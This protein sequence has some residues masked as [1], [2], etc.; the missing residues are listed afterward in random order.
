VNNVNPMGMS[1]TENHLQV[2]ILLP[3]CSEETPV[4]GI[5]TPTYGGMIAGHTQNLY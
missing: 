3:L 1:P 5:H 4:A 2:E